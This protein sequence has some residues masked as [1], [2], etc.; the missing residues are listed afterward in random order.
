MQGFRLTRAQPPF[1][2]WRAGRTGKT[3]SVGVLAW[4]SGSSAE[5]NEPGSDGAAPPVR[6]VAPHRGPPAG[7]RAASS[8]EEPG[9]VETGADRGPPAGHR[10]A[11]SV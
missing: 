6:R 3:A 1:A 4:S 10:A 9:A 7:H 8:V 2:A 11:S 5:K